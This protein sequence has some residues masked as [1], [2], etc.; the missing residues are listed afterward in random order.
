MMAWGG[1]R[2]APAGLRR[3]APLFAAALLAAC[4]GSDAPPPPADAVHPLAGDVAATAPGAERTADS[5]TPAA[6]DSG[7]ACP[8]F[9]VWHSC[10]VQQRLE[11][12]GFVLVP[13]RDSVGQPGL[14]IPGAAYRLGSAELQLYLYA[15]STDAKAQAA[16]VDRDE[17][18]A[19]EVQGIL[20]PPA[21]IRSN[22]L[23]ALLFG[24][25]DRQLERVQLA[26]TAGL[27]AR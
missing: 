16:R 4:G 14:D 24:N 19:A 1:A 17:A 23:V 20:R 6:P 9:G 2:P 3:C 8:M 10:S 12:A 15:D 7:E 22:N 26:L 25:N 27:P 11:R 13:A 18:S 5:T 21:V